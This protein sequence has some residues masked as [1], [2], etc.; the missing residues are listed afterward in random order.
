MRERRGSGEEG[1]TEGKGDEGGRRGRRGGGVCG[2]RVEDDKC[3]GKGDIL[4]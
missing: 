2:V 4:E 1:K 3:F